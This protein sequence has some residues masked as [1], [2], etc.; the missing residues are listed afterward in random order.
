MISR[1]RLPGLPASKRSSS[2][3][4]RP[5]VPA[6]GASPP[7]ARMVGVDVA[8]GVALLA[9]IASHVFDEGDAIV[10]QP[11]MT[12][13]IVAGR[14]AATFTLV[15]GLSVAFLTGGRNVVR[16]PARTAASA[17]LAVRALLIG[18]IGLL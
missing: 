7:S 18:A 1:I 15:A 14:S 11:T 3:P 17:G 6:V 5:T 13:V 9:M 8:R 10:P 4:G 2:G 12:D 16:G